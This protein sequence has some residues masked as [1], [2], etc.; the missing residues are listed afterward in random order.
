[1]KIYLETR[2][3]QIPPAFIHIHIT[4]F[5]FSLVECLI[6]PLAL[7]LAVYCSNSLRKLKLKYLASI[8]FQMRILFTSN[9]IKLNGYPHNYAG[10]FSFMKL[11][12]SEA[13]IR[14]GKSS[15][16]QKIFRKF[17]KELC[18]HIQRRRSNIAR[19]LQNGM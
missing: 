3:S 10:M 4:Q 9:Y 14:M 7:H 15:N 2:I 11:H 18:S 16:N 8:N 6:Y 13:N 19:L 1:M 12:I 5:R 17:R